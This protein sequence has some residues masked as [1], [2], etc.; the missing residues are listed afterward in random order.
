[1]AGGEWPDANPNHTFWQFNSIL[2]D[3]KE[4]CSLQ[5]PRSELGLTIV[6]G[7]VYALGFLTNKIES[8]CNKS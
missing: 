6:D 8:K 7:Y 1:M 5:I 4:L 2:D 3:W